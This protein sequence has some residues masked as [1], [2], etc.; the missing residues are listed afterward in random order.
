MQGSHHPA[1][2]WTTLADGRVECR[3][4][5][6][7]CKL[8]EEGRGLCFIRRRLGDELVLDSYGR[9]TGFC[10]DPVEKKPLHHFLP[11]TPVLS[12]GTAGCNLSCRFCQNWEMSKAR[13][14][15]RLSAA[16]GPA[17]IAAVAAELGCSAVAYTYNDPV[18]F[19][20]YAVDTAA[21]C[22]ERGIR[23]IAVTAGY[24]EAKPRVEFFGAMDAANVDLKSFDPEFYRRLTGSRLEP[25][26]ETLEY[27]SRE[28]ECWLE[29]TTLLIPGENDGDAELTALAEW[30]HERLGPE[31]PLHFSAFHP[32]FRM[33]DLPPTPLATLTRARRLALEI[34]LNHVY[35]GNV[36]DREGAST[37]CPGCDELL[38]ERDIYTL[39]RWGLD[40]K[41]SCARCGRPLAGVFDAM[42]GNW[43]ARRLP[44]DL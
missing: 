35:T 16:A 19:L 42:P 3:L 40:A 34:G 9:S 38:I 33:K 23:S 27:L 12:F 25:V 26:L 4:C 44:I 10:V 22:A 31:T 8:K 13:E 6:H 17:E 14:I 41:G 11:G 1:R 24:I 7:R 5:P 37:R 30:V 32:D 21:A 2:Y 28:T 15:D 39:G 36:R 29:I 18:I 20:E 43:G